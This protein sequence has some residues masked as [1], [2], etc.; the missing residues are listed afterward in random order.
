ML[1]ARLKD[2]KKEYNQCAVSYH[3]FSIVQ[4]QDEKSQAISVSRSWRSAIAS[5]Y[6]SLPVDRNPLGPT[7]LVVASLE[8]PPHW[9]HPQLDKKTRKDR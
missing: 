3:L 1:K 8:D 9:E 2:V 6:P 4:S 7:N 5:G